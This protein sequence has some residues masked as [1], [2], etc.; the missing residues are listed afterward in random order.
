MIEEF[1]ARR[2]RPDGLFPG[3]PMM[4]LTTTG[5][6]RSATNDATM[7]LVSIGRNRAMRERQVRH[8][9]WPWSPGWR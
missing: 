8:S 2:E 6:Q 1:R 9:A 4:L 7:G 5:A 3:R